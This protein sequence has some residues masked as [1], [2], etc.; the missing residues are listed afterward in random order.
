[1]KITDLAIIATI[2]CLFFLFG[3]SKNEYIPCCQRQYIFDLNGPDPQKILHDPRCNQTD[4][5][6]FGICDPATTTSSMANC[7][8]G[9]SCSQLDK[10]TCVKTNNCY[11]NE[12]SRRC[13]GDT[14]YWFMPICA[15]PA[16]S[17]CINDKCAAMVCGYSK[18]SIGPAPTAKDFDEEKKKGPIEVSSQA[19]P[20]SGVGLLGKSCSIKTMDQNLYNKVVQSKGNLW[21]NSFRF[22]VGRSF[23]DFEQARYFFPIS[24][25]FCSTN[26]LG[27]KDRFMNYL[28]AP[29]TWCASYSGN[30]YHCSKT[31]MNFSS[32]QKCQDYCFGLLPPQDCEVISTSTKY[33]CI[34]TEFLYNDQKDCQLECPI[35]SQPDLCSNDQTKFPFLEPDARYKSVLQADYI[36]GTNNYKSW[37]TLWKPNCEGYKEACK[38]EN[39]RNLGKFGNYHHGCDDFEPYACPEDKLDTRECLWSPGIGGHRQGMRWMNNRQ[40]TLELDTM[41]YVDRLK[42][43]IENAPQKATMFECEHGGQ[44]LS[45]VCDKTQYSRET[46]KSTAGGPVEC[47]CKKEGGYRL[48]CGMF[49]DGSTYNTSYYM[50]EAINASPNKFGFEATYSSVIFEEGR[51]SSEQ[52]TVYIF[53]QPYGANIPPKPST[54]FQILKNCQI[55]PLQSAVYFSDAQVGRSKIDQIKMCLIV[56][57]EEPAKIQLLPENYPGLTI[58][59]DN[60]TLN[61]EDLKG[62]RRTNEEGKIVYV[63][64]Y[65][66]LPKEENGEGAIGVCKL[67]DIPAFAT[68]P[69][70]DLTRLGWC[71]PCTYATLA[72]QKINWNLRGWRYNCYAFRAYYNYSASNGTIPTMNPAYKVG[73]GRST[74][75]NAYDVSP[76]KRDFVLFGRR[77]ERQNGNLA[78]GY[79]SSRLGNFISEYVCE[80]GWGNIWVYPTYPEERVEM[81]YSNAKQTWHF[82]LMIDPSL[83]YV[84]QK[85]RDYLAAGVIP[86][87]DISEGGPSVSAVVYDD[88]LTFLGL[89]VKES[90]RLATQTKKLPDVDG[91]VIYAIANISHI[92]NESLNGS[93]VA[94]DG[95]YN[96]ELASYLGIK[97]NSN[98]QKIVEL[99]GG[100][101]LTIYSAVFFKETS[102]NPPLIAID[103]GNPEG[104]E[105]FVFG[106]LDEFF[107]KPGENGREWR[108]RNGVPDK[109]PGYVDLLLQEWVPMCNKGGVSDEEKIEKEFE[110]RMNLSR[111]FLKNYSRPT[112]VWRFHFT[113]N[114]YCNIDKFLSY[115]FD[116]QAQMVDSG[117]IGLIYDAWLTEDGKPYVNYSHANWDGGDATG[118]TDKIENSVLTLE[119]L[120]MQSKTDVFCSLQN[121][122]KKILGMTRLTYGQKVYA[123]NKSCM[124]EVCKDEDVISG[125]CQKPHEDYQPGDENLP[126]LYCMDGEK[127][128]MPDSS[129]TNY[130]YYRCPAMC[131]NATACKKCKDI[132]PPTAG[133]NLFCRIETSDNRIFRVLKN[134]S[135]LTDDYWDII[136]ALQNKDKCCLNMSDPQNNEEIKYTYGKIEGV[137]QRT[138]F[139]QYPKRGD[140]GIDCGRAPD[141]SVLKYCNVKIP[142]S[143]NHLA[144]WKVG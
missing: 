135:Q 38:Q 134:Y 97:Q 131:V 60:C 98:N 64:A 106:T 13:I 29:S 50:L 1:M 76:V 75:E 129:W 104:K 19:D 109:Y 72:V 110:Y 6:Y 24:D 127:C 4:G 9:K 85:T 120:G 103:V 117:I 116:H 33:R 91:A 86:I 118:T 80:D 136:A 71:M 108:M 26:M 100:K 36:Y 121:H 89:P 70:F 46:C 28:N 87:L 140:I 10:A 59:D 137:K 27:G 105:Q 96:S 130:S 144:C 107:Y 12:T 42:K 40:F 102:K 61:G 125:A 3:C 67:N 35:I 44:C 48:N 114:T 112:I 126:Q 22:G 23:S 88:V 141:T 32:Q 79:Y 92:N 119:R 93:V 94:G 77:A 78:R 41:Y 43:Q 8:N 16:P 65:H 124:C 74:R 84:V 25:R 14:A 99:K 18:I 11:W 49:G 54:T 2:L 30:V 123:E 20:L 81:R 139:I 34:E 90:I 7:T 51:F 17:N 69:Y 15:D 53:T 101:N 31:G 66:F 132:V 47:G 122:S 95:V 37:C 52:G 55:Q 115:L 143:N 138:E 45:G 73:W 128:Q 83:P 113:S 62:S 21:V 57:P 5:T 68:P 133:S 82:Q 111:Q 63:S 39:W 58:N 56:E 142:L